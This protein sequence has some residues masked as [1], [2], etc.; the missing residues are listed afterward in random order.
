[1]NECLHFNAPFFQHNLKHIDKHCIET[2]WYIRN[3]SEQ[4]TPH[5]DTVHRC[6]TTLGVCTRSFLSTVM[7]CAVVCG[8]AL[9]QCRP[10][11]PLVRSGFRCTVVRGM[12]SQHSAFNSLSS[13][14]TFF[15]QDSSTARAPAR[16]AQPGCPT[17]GLPSLQPRLA[18]AAQNP[19][20]LGCGLFGLCH[21]DPTSQIMRSPQLTVNSI[22]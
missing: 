18:A 2:R 3:V 16:T 9:A 5:S 7:H 6:T 10:A 8:P 19:R 4:T 21:N 11:C 22:F 14:Y 15:L 17:A 12:P 20:L 13:S 1:M